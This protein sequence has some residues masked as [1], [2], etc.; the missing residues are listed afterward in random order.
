M[1]QLLACAGKFS[2]ASGLLPTG[3]QYAGPP[4]TAAPSSLFSA[5]VN[6]GNSPAASSSRADLSNFLDFRHRVIV[7]VVCS[8]AQSPSSSMMDFPP[9]WPLPGV[10][11]VRLPA[12]RLANRLLGESATPR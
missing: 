10:W 4:S 2:G 7:F 12:P 6:S 3:P 9:G 11:P 5:S 1:L 8:D